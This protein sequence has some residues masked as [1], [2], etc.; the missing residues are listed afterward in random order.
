MNYSRVEKYRNQ[1]SKKLKKGLATAL[2]GTVLVSPIALSSISASA[3]SN[4]N[5]MDS[6]FS[7]NRSL[8]N[9]S[10]RI[11]LKWR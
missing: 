9:A 2:M 1:K 8:R 7:W 6:K 5:W 10:P 4:T 3:T 11:K